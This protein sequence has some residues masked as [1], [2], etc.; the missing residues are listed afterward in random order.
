[1]KYVI[2]VIDYKRDY[3]VATTTDP[4]LL[5]VLSDLKLAEVSELFIGHN[6]SVSVNGRQDIT[7]SNFEDYEGWIIGLERATAWQSGIE[8]KMTGKDLA[9]PLIETAH[10]GVSSAVDPSHYRGMLAGLPDYGWIDIESRK[11]K[12]KDPTVFLGAVD[13]QESK[14][15]E[16][17]GQKDEPLQERKKSLFY[18]MYAILYMENGCLP[19]KA[20]E[21]HKWIAAMPAMPHKTM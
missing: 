5:N 6:L 14:Y 13:L 1:M 11:A 15:M 19:I 8:E 10:I 2:D 9:E 17:L 16:R 21:V 20:D 7:L 3:R 12:Y 4:L 18:K